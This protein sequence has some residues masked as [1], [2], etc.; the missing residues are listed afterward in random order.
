MS[1]PQSILR[2]MGEI[3]DMERGKLCPMR[4]GRYFNHQ[5][6][7]QGRNMAHYVPAA[8]VTALQTSI[9]GYRRFVKLVEQY[10]ALIVQQTRQRRR[11][12]SSKLHS[13]APRRSR[14]ARQPQNSQKKEE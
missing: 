12:A 9:T 3:Q 13:R 6:W 5:T 1:T 2:Q 14:I 4:G 7:E 11:Q 10:V 8:Q